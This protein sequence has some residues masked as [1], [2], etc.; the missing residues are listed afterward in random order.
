MDEFVDELPA[1]LD[2]LNQVVA[3]LPGTA[4]LT[5]V[6][7]EA[8]WRAV[9]QLNIDGVD[10]A[11]VFIHAHDGRTWAIA[12]SPARTEEENTVLW[13]GSSH[14]FGDGLHARQYPRE[15]GAP[16]EALVGAPS[17]LAARIAEQLYEVVPPARDAIAAELTK[18]RETYSDTIAA[19]APT[20]A[21]L[22]GEVA[23]TAITAD[24]DEECSY[25][26][27][28]ARRSADHAAAVWFEPNDT[29][30]VGIIGYFPEGP[31]APK[32]AA[33]IRAVLD[34]YDAAGEEVA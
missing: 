8:R 21:A 26:F 34:E 16:V 24:E 12:V 28:A 3:A 18:L 6:S 13:G 25:G 10:C 14:L 9:A 1:T 11:E 5:L 29:C 20:A 7:E 23:Y 22:G 33:A 2:Y 4:T 19:I 17:E 30:S 15:R 27:T 32:I 31:M